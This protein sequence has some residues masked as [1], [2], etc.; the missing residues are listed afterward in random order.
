MD[1]SFRH[2][3]LTTLGS[4]T[5]AEL[6]DISMRPQIVAELRD[7]LEHVTGKGVI[8]RIYLPQYVIQ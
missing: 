3:L 6:S 2:T 7:S 8:H 1:V 5:V 4:R